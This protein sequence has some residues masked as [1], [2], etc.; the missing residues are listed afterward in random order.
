MHVTLS[1]LP[2]IARSRKFLPTYHIAHRFDTTC[3][4]SSLPALSPHNFKYGTN[5][6]ICPLQHRW[7]SNS[8]FTSAST[9]AYASHG[10]QYSNRSTQRKYSLRYAA[11]ARYIGCR[12][13]VQYSQHCTLC[14]DG[15]DL[16][17]CDMANCDR[18][19]CSFCI[20]IPPGELDRVRS[21][22]VFRCV[23]CHWRMTVTGNPGPYYVSVF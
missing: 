15:G 3:S 4:Q 13:S 18:A 8:P 14:E 10:R 20:K 23:P 21:N 22:S 6:T 1:P 17:V 11:F 2:Y 9:Q 16:W 5:K 19:V 7:K 12:A